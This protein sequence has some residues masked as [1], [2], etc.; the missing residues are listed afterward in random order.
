[1]EM[2]NL[3]TSN[4]LDF[5]VNNLSQIF[6][7]NHNYG[8]VALKSSLKFNEM[9]KNVNIIFIYVDFPNKFGL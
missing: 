7:N 6:F 2:S 1:V 5:E 3:Y 4:Q 8:N 9:I